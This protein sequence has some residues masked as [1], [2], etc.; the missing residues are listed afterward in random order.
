MGIRIGLINKFKLKN[1]EHCIDNFLLRRE[2][3]LGDFSPVIFHDFIKKKYFKNWF[4]SQ[5]VFKDFDYF[6]HPGSF[7]I[8]YSMPIKRKK[9]QKTKTLSINY[10]WE[11]SIPVSKLYTKKKKQNN[12]I[13][14]IINK[15]QEK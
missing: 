11:F 7:R 9:K 13:I 12:K 3:T 1:E 6:F 15:S 4:L 5:N 14:I 8:F 10:R 2:L